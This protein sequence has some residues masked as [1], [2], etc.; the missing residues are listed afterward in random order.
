MKKLFN[1]KETMAD[2]MIDGFVAAYPDI[3]TFGENRRVVRRTQLKTKEGKVGA[4]CYGVCRRRF[5][6]RKRGW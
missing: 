6:G 3:V 2:D 1:S 4:D 5:I